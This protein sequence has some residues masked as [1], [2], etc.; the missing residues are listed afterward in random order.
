LTSTDS[1]PSGPEW[2][3]A[4]RPGRTGRALPLLLV[5]AYVLLALAW[6]L[7]NPAGAAPDEPAHYLKALA[8]AGGHPAGRPVHLPVSPSD[9][10]RQTWMKRTTRGVDV[11]AG[12]SPAGLG[13]NAL[14]PTESAR[15][16]RVAHPAD[17]PSRG[18]TYIGTHQPLVYL[19]PG[20]LARLG[21]DPVTAI[22]LGRVGNALTSV[23]LLLAAVA[24]L[25]DRDAGVVSV[26]GLVVAVTPMVVFLASSLTASGPEVAGAVC[27]LAALLR[28]GR[29]SSGEEPAWAWV[30]LAV[31]GVVLA[32]SRTLGPLWVVLLALVAVAVDGPGPARRAV[33]AGGRRAVWSLA[34]VAA[35]L[36]GGVGW[37]LAVQ[38][39]GGVHAGELVR[40]V[41]PSL[42][43]LP[44]LVRQQIGVFGSLDAA[45]PP[46]AYRCWSLLVLALVLLALWV[47]TRRQ[48]AV[49]VV[50]PVA[51]VAVTVA[52][53]ALNRS[54]TGFGMQ[55]RYVLA[56]AV[57][58]PLVAGETLFRN[59]PAHGAF[60]GEPLLALVLVS[61]AAVQALGWYV[62]ARRSAVGTEAPW[63]F[64]GRSE[65]SPPLG[66][67]PLVAVVAVAAGMMALSAV[68]SLARAPGRAGPRP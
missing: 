38:P 64:I 68:G 27:F 7:G 50:L 49:L 42:R 57:A 29:R 2:A 13:C 31:G 36:A 40:L 48:R 22:R 17:Q 4:A 16:Q 66:W 45:M 14:H 23:G 43:Q 11:P 37:E 61:A 21:H 20:A 33:R 25:W 55:G 65:W 56:F 26:V 28:L 35:A 19:L 12:L 46:V 39:H 54:Q 60:A 51:I 53:A 58:L 5:P 10:E 47:G 3:E 44:E 34:A 41:G 18:L 62:N 32:S 30:A 59:R 6:M 15:C 9:D 63:L 1:R 24:L 8:V 67:Y 52:V